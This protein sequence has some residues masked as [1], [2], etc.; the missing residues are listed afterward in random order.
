MRRRRSAA[1]RKAGRAASTALV[2]LALAS[3][4]CTGDAATDTATDAVR[5]IGTDAASPTAVPANTATDTAPRPSTAG[6]LSVDSSW[7]WQ[8]QG[9]VDTGR[10]VDVFDIDLF[11]TP[12][13]AIEALHAA[14]RTVICYFSAGSYE[15]WRSDSDGFAAS[16]L[17]E[18]LDGFADER[19]LDIRRPSVR[20]VALGRL[21]RAVAAGCDGVEPDNVDGYVNDSGFDLTGDDQ[22]DF[23][24]FL[25]DEAH[26]RGLVIGLKNDVDQL[27][28]LVD[29]F[30]FA[31][32]E[33]C[34]EYDE[35]DGYSVFVDQGKPVFVAEYA[36]RFVDE[37]DLVC[38]AARRADLRA[39]ILPLDLDDSF[40]IDCDE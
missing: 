36:S 17:G 40:R 8:L 21:D 26:R 6:L 13:E 37:P 39:L 20:A 16:D 27:L 3:S 2:L 9:T 15:P 19:W 33:Q 23:N 4:A 25:A 30:D 7:H 11:D 10:D 18:P 38:L 1:Q 12:P 5:E 14:G 29:H 28:D 22:L 32:N 31:L 34:H 35:C 24:R